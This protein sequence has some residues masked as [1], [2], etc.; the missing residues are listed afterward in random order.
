[1]V[2]KEIQIEGVAE[3]NKRRTGVNHILHKLLS[4]PWLQS[5]FPLVRR[6]ENVIEAPGMVSVQTIP[7][8]L[9]PKQDCKG[10]T[11]ISANMWHDW[12]KRRRSEQ[13]L[14]AF[15]NLVDEHNA[16]VLLLQEVARTTNFW[17]DRWLAKRLGMAYVYSRA[18]GHLEGIGFEEG[19][20]VFSRYPLN[21]PVLRQ[22]S[23]AENQFVHRL[24]LGTQI[25]SPCGNLLVF[26]VHLSLS[27]KKNA[28]EAIRLTNWVQDVSGENSALVGGD[29]NAGE[30]SKQMKQLQRNWMDTFRHINPFADGAT[31]EL[32]WP[33]GRSIRRERLDYI[34]LK[35][36]M[37]RWEVLDARHLETLGEQHSDHRAVLLRLAPIRVP[38]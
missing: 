12:P 27:G 29:F 14:E 33:W 4:L 36:K 30:N 13:R 17:T 23:P 26:S 2:A 24:A 38:V 18:N 11:I 28:S 20:A 22:L 8:N 37:K 9:S 3:N 34:F 6:V 16:D 25:D 15:A 5:S 31:H 10:L 19:L 7:D 35:A 1:M 21:Q 32:H